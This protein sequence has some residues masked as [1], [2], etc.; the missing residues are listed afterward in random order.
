MPFEDDFFTGDQWKNAETMTLENVYFRPDMDICD[1]N[2]ISML[3]LAHIGDSVYELLVRTMLCTQGHQSV[4]ELHKLTVSY[5]NA[6]SQAK[7]AEKILPVLS[8]EEK[9]AYKKSFFKS[10]FL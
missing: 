8:D 7:A 2:A 5:V 3:G 10:T 9:S 6:P 1:I 4:T